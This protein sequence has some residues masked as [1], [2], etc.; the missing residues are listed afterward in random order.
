[1]AGVALAHAVNAN[2]VRRWLRERGISFP[3]RLSVAV[4]DT[5]PAFVP[6]TLPPARSE[7]GPIV[8]E[9]RR[10]TTVIHVAWPLQAAGDCAVWL[11]DWLR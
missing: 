10:G 2:Q 4:A 1:M 9:V 5:A 6:V 7:T 8:I 11:R 3:A